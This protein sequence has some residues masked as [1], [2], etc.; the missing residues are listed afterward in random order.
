MFRTCIP[1]VVFGVAAC[2]TAAS[3]TPANNLNTRA[4]G[5]VIT[6]GAPPPPNASFSAVIDGSGNIVRGV[7][8]TSADEASTG[9]YQVQFNND[10]TSCAFV[11]TPGQPGSSGD[12][13][14]TYSTVVGQAGT[15]NGLFIQLFDVNGNLV[16]EPFHVDVGC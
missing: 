6:N 16:S 9:S 10:L 1:Y 4:R 8:V 5:Q 14:A 11:V 7:G 15:N 3:A 13:P 2:V 12:V